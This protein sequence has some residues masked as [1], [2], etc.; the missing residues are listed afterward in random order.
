MGKTLRRVLIVLGYAYPPIS[1]NAEQ[2]FTRT[3]SGVSPE[4]RRASILRMASFLDR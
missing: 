3:N 4:V 2:A 1:K